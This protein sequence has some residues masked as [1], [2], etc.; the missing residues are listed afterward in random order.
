[1]DGGTTWSE[2]WRSFAPLTIEGVRGTLKLGYMTELSP[3]HL[4][5]VAMWI[6]RST[7]PGKPLFNPKTEGCLPMSAVLAESHI[8]IH[9]W[10]EYGDAALD[11]FM[12]GAAN[13]NATIDVMKEAF[14]PG[15]V[16]V[17][18][19]LRGRE[20][21]RWKGGSKRRSMPASASA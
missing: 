10:P 5:V 18:T 19:Q 9:S 20:I 13:P 16:V 14:A 7:H 12:C 17:K 11:V 3:G 2:P 8:S 21:Q 1:M 6:D 15:K 4:I